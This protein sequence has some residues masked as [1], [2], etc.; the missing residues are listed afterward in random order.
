V[1]WQLDLL[2][3]LIVIVLAV[4]ALSVRSLLAAV[5][6]LSAF[7]LVVAVMFAGL[8]AVDVAFVEAV[9]GAGLSGLLFLLLIRSTGDRLDSA[10]P[11]RGRLPVAGLVGVFVVLM[12]VAGA[13][14][15]PRGEP[16]APAQERVAREY[17]ERSVP[18]TRTPNVVTAVLADF[19]SQDTLAE[20][21]VIFTA[22]TAVVLILAPRGRRRGTG[23][24]EAADTEEAP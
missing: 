4:L 24:A 15:P 7:S 2:L 9:L 19:R 5:P 11:T 23:A 22:G 6:I 18:E 10:R 3:F 20:L 8:A 14:L 13:G 21:V 17:L 12:V 1:I 16:D